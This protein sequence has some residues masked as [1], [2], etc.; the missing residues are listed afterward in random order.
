[1]ALATR[2]TELTGCRVPVQ[3]A[4]MGS[5][6][7]IGLAV[8]VAEAGGVGSIVMRGMRERGRRARRISL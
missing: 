1:M 2:F 3:Q 7:T 6:A 5:V 4:P 8:A